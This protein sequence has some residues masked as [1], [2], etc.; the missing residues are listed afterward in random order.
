MK[1]KKIFPKKIII[2]IDGVMTSGHMLY[3][4][5]GKNAKIF[6]PDDHDALKLLKK[7]CSIEFISADTL[8]FKISKKRI[9]DHM[10]FK[11]TLVPNKD[12]ES[13][14]KKKVNLKSILYMGDGIF[15]HKIFS[16]VGY[17]IAFKDS[18]EH[19]KKKADFVVN[20]V[21]SN[22]AVAEAS[23]YI[24]KKFFGYKDF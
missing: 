4:S 19:V 8:G 24:L 11:I 22:R 16:L 14:F 9:N 1:K 10:N 12:K 7:Y 13:W 21:G 15:D 5:K 3:T 18:L 20:R 23:L 17:S 2:D 6:G